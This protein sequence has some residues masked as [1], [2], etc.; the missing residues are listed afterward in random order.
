MAGEHARN[1]HPLFRII[2]VTSVPGIPQ[3]V[4][5][6]Y[7]P[8]L[9]YFVQHTYRRIDPNC[10]LE[11]SWNPRAALFQISMSFLTRNWSR[12]PVAYGI[13]TDLKSPVTTFTSSNLIR[14]GFVS[15][16]VQKFSATDIAMFN[17]QIPRLRTQHQSN[18]HPSITGSFAARY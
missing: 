3:A 1:S 8:R 12:D 4:L 17:F 16:M 5:C 18:Y 7:T 10:C 2:H 6:K 9:H 15:N 13:G 14:V 11:M